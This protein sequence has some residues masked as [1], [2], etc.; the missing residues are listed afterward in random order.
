[1]E[2]TQPVV[3]SPLEG[4]W[5]GKPREIRVRTIVLEVPAQERRDRPEEK[6]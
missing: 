3:A 5:A 6:Q 1:M 2:Y 4:V